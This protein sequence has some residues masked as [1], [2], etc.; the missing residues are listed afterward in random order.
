M[1]PISIMMKILLSTATV[2]EHIYFKE[3]LAKSP[4]NKE[5]YSSF[6]LLRQ[7]GSAIDNKPEGDTAALQRIRKLLYEAEIKR[8]KKQWICFVLFS[9]FF[10]GLIILFMLFILSGRW[11]ME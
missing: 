7:M 6:K 2:Q 4:E 11:T 5:E 10:S 1:D 3:W 9:I 8:N